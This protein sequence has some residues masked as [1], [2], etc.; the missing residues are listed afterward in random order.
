MVYGKDGYIES[1]YRVIFRYKDVGSGSAARFGKVEVCCI[2]VSGQYHVA[3]LIGDAV[4]WVRGN[5][6]KYLCNGFIRVLCG[7]RLLGSNFSEAM[8]YYNRAPTMI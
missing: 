7:R 1:G 2:G 4:F 8:V 5:I 6:V 3:G